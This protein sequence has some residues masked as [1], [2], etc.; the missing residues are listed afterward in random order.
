M[1]YF[2]MGCRYPSR[3]K[4]F[5]IPFLLLMPLT[6]LAQRYND[7][8]LIIV[9]DGKSSP[10]PEASAP[11]LKT[12]QSTEPAPSA[13][14]AAAPEAS[15]AATIPETPPIPPNFPDWAVSQAGQHSSG[16]V[17]PVRP[18]RPESPESPARATAPA[19]PPGADKPASP[20]APE[21]PTGKLWPR[22]TVPIF[23]KS[24][25]GF[26]LEL[27]PACTCVITELMATMPHD[28][29]LKLSAD[30]SIE[31]DGRVVHAR[32]N[33]IAAPTRKN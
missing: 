11:G 2:C 17:E 27:I 32:Q 15:A 4:R 28:E 22:D 29:F 16:N 13:T 10:A 21:F 6:V 19:S 14:A 9:G 5:L 31:N 1:V 7:S 12:S 33:C 30:G 18:P 3:M 20:A 26:H 8:P 23:V 25:I 24:C